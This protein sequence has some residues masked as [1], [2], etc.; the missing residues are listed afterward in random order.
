MNTPQTETKT[1]PVSA[2]STVEPRPLARTAPTP[3]SVRAAQWALPV[4]LLAFIALFSMLQPATFATQG[5]FTTLLGSEAVLILVAL[6]AMLP[7]IVGQYDLSVGANMG[8]ASI[9]VAMATS[10]LGFSTGGGIAVAIVLSTLLGFVNGF[11]VAKIGISSFVA[12]LAVSSLLSGI[13]IWSTDGTVIVDNIPS[14]LTDIGRSSILYIPIP[15]LLVIVIALVTGYVLRMTPTGRYLY[16]VGGSSEASRLSGL[17]VDRL[18]IMTFAASGL[19][20]GIG[21]VLLVSKL[22]SANPTT[23]PEFLLPAFAACFLGA[24]S[25][26]PGSFNVTGTILA[27]LV[28]AVGSTGLQ[29]IGVPFYIEPIF[30]G[31][32]LLIAALVTRFLRKEQS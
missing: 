29:L 13:V 22:G 2:A 24:T 5:N 14:A 1:S 8:M 15:F 6:G 9:A 21:G 3:T 25:I 27:V 7:L 23:G 4:I 11:L 17:S 30:A 26:R 19:L 20:C 32:V 28:L 18:T 10:E 16:A 31:V 12:T